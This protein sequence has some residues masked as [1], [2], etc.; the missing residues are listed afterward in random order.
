MTDH[1]PA[2]GDVLRAIADGSYDDDIAQLSR[3]ISQRIDTVRA[4]RART[5]RQT[6]REGGQGV[7]RGFSSHPDIN[8]SVVTVLEIRR[9]RCD[10][11]LAD[12]RAYSVPL[13]TVES[14]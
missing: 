11:R 4:V 8:D 7:L 3:A 14:L 12:G 2:Y 9:T 13:H 10:V 6:L 1:T 5:N